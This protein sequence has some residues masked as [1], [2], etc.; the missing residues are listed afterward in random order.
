MAVLDPN[1][2]QTD[3]ISG[4][5]VMKEILTVVGP[6]PDP[7]YRPGHP[8]AVREWCVNTAVVDNVTKAA[9]VNNEDGKVYRWDFTTNSL[10]EVV[11]L[12]AGLGE[13]Y[14]PTLIG[15]HGTVFAIN[16]AILFA[17]GQ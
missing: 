12:T 8:H 3:P 10:T 1:A 7:D 6:T 16:N 14:T 11:T 2:T 17:V 15:T 4:A 13:A 5:T 9:M